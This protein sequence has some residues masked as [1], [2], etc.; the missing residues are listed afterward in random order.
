M[1][2]LF[3]N[4]Y[5]ENIDIDMTIK[6]MIHENIGNSI[7]TQDMIHKIIRGLYFCTKK[8]R[9][10]HFRFSHFLTFHKSS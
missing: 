9:V 8:L 10:I 7:F 4:Y 1:N 2:G 5:G 3:F 6:D